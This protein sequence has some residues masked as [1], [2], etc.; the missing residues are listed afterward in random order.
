M[1]ELTVNLDND[2]DNEEDDEDVSHTEACTEEEG[3]PDVVHNKDVDEDPFHQQY[4]QYQDPTT[5]KEAINGQQ[6]MSAMY[7]NNTD[8]YY[9]RV[10]VDTENNKPIP[11]NM[12]LR[13][14]C[15][16]VHL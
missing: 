12:S 2:N 4:H 13:H 5:V 3:G 14:R 9:C 10:Q 15:V 6:V 1:D 11:T 16:L 8:Q 7:D